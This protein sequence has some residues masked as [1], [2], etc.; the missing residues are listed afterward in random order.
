MVSASPGSAF[1]PIFTYYLG[2]D[3]ALAVGLCLIATIC[4]T[5]TFPI[6]IYLFCLVSNISIETFVPLRE[7]LYFS[8]TQL[9]PLGVGCLVL[10]FKPQWASWLKKAGPIWALAIIITSLITSLSNYGNILINRWDVYCMPLLLGAISYFVGFTIPRIFGLDTKQVRAICFN[11][12]LQNS[13]LALT[14][15][16]VL[17]TPSC[18]Q[19]ISL[20]PLHQTF[21]MIVEGLIIGIVMFFFF[22]IV[23]P[24]MENSEQ[25][26]NAI[27]PEENKAI[28]QEY[29]NEFINANTSLNENNDND[30]DSLPS[31]DNVSVVDIS[32]ASI[33]EMEKFS[34][35]NPTLDTHPPSPSSRKEEKVIDMNVIENEDSIPNSINLNSR[36][37]Q[38][39]NT[40]L[41]NHNKSFQSSRHSSHDNEDTYHQISHSFSKNSSSAVVVSSINRDNSKNQTTKINRKNSSSQIIVTEQNHHNLTRNESTKTLFSKYRKSLINVSS[42]V[43][44]FIIDFFGK[45]NES[46]EKK[47]NMMEKNSSNKI[48]KENTNNNNSNK[49]KSSLESTKEQLSSPV[50]NNNEMTTVTTNT[51]SKRISLNRES[52]E[53]FLDCDNESTTTDNKGT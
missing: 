38:H 13:P 20:I 2:G 43:N 42:V 7:T 27:K 46:D 47:V 34:P 1:A 10:H 53:E 24:I 4:G 9:I 36:P 8:G 49:S 32:D 37:I 29:N 3:R 21:W 17:G 25:P 19:L 52:T 48:Y 33:Y 40:A 41:S 18:A 12:G 50:L 31:L 26:I 39:S 11:T 51:L 16:Q 35:I 22:P 45:H 30:N 28:L 15:I 23:K 44:S 5:F 14:I 6:I